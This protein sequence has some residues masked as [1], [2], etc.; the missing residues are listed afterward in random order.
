MVWLDRTIISYY[1]TSTALTYHNLYFLLFL[2]R[3]QG[4]CLIH[5]KNTLMHKSFELNLQCDSNLHFNVNLYV[6]E[7]IYY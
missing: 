3:F 5:A 7:K 2:P 1:G 6:T 4:F